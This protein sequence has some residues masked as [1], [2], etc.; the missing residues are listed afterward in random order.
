MS[1]QQME[2]YRSRDMA[3]VTFLRMNGHRPLELNYTRER[4]AWW[5][6]ARSPMLTAMVQE[7]NLG[8]GRVDPK[9][10]SRLSYETRSELFQARDEF[11]QA[12]IA[13]AAAAS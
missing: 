10:F 12:R 7:F 9:E 13:N 4:G 8:E 2:T 1:P 6:F 11:E 5:V 3:M